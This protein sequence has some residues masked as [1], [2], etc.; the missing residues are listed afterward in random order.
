[1]KWAKKEK[2][3]EN[4]EE[5]FLINKQLSYNRVL[6]FYGILMQSS[7]YFTFMTGIYQ[8]RTFE[9][10]MRTCPVPIKLGISLI[11]PLY[12]VNFLKNKN[13]YN[14]D[15]YELAIKYREKYDPDGFEK[16][17]DFIRYI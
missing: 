4:N 16:E 1:M 9:Y 15:L 3:P 10:S 13:M 2:W 12:A 8:W 7:F 14:A 11:T 6:I 5:R 17:K